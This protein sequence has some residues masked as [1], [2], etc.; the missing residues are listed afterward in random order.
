MSGS[1]GVINKTMKNIETEKAYAWPSKTDHD[2]EYSFLLTECGN[3][4][5][6]VNTDPMHRNGCI[7][8]KC[9]KIVQVVVPE[10][11]LNE[12]MGVK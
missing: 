3:S 10:I 11:D 2:G 9:G 12:V 8:P 5:Y 7:C 6:S 1:I 4:W